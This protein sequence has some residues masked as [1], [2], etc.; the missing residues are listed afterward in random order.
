MAEVNRIAPKPV[1]VQSEQ[2]S[3]SLQRHSQNHLVGRDRTKAAASALETERLR[4]ASQNGVAISLL[5][6]QLAEMKAIRA[7]RQTERLVHKVTAELESS[8]LTSISSS[9]LPLSSLIDDPSARSSQ[10]L[11]I[12]AAQKIFAPCS[13][14]SSSFVSPSRIAQAAEPQQQPYMDRRPTH[15]GPHMTGW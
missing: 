6:Q 13:P 8:I 5:S 2:W 11:E 4:T 3:P 10:P 1:P 14:I 7:Q 15:D 12:V 9:P